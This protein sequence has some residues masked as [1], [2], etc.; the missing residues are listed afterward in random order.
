M[1]RMWTPDVIR[2]ALLVS[3]SAAW[4]GVQL[5][6]WWRAFNARAL[7]FH[8]RA[9]CLFPPLTAYVAYRQGAR[10]SALLWLALLVV[11]VALRL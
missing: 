1:A 3:V 9:A 6:L 2:F 7:P 11:Y 5:R 8:M 4:C 10:V